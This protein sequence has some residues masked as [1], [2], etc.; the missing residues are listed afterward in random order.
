MLAE[1]A[2]PAAPSPTP[3]TAARA[4]C[5]PQTRVRAFRPRSVEYNYRSRRAA[6]R[7]P[8]GKL[9]SVRRLASDAGFY[10]FDGIDHPRRIRQGA[11]TAYYEL[12]LAFNVRRLRASGG[13]DLGGYRYSAF[14]QMKVDTTSVAQPL[15]WKGR[16]SSSVAGGTY[17]VRARQW[18]PEVAVF[19]ALDEYEWQTTRTTLWGWPGMSGTSLTDPRGHGPFGRD[20]WDCLANPIQCFLGPPDGDGGG[21]SGGGGGGGGGLQQCPQQPPGPPPCKLERG[22]TDLLYGLT[23]CQYVCPDGGKFHFSTDRSGCP[24]NF[25]DIR[26]RL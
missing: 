17:D 21:G 6:R 10:L 24:K 8:S 4:S 16:W 14:G 9:A 23:Y 1:T 2:A 18:A 12:D 11:T 13:V 19:L 26:D 7:R 15:R 3:S 5:R 22:L 25:P 20:L